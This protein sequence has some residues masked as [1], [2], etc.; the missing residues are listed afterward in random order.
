MWKR[1]LS[2]RLKR[3]EGIK[4]DRML[5]IGMT[6]A[7]FNMQSQLTTANNLANLQ[8]I[9]FKAQF[10][11]AKAVPVISN[12]LPTRTYGIV[13][14]QGINFENGAKTQTFNPLDIA[15]KDK[16]YIVVQDNNQVKLTRNGALQVDNEGFLKT[17]EGFKVMGENGPI[18]VSSRNKL[19][20]NVDGY[21]VSD[22][23]LM[24]RIMLV[25][26]S[27]ETLSKD[28]SGLLMSTE[29]L[30]QDDSIKVDVGF[31]EGS[32]VNAQQEMI[33]MIKLS[34]QFDLN[35]KVIDTANENAKS[36]QKILQL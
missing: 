28:N 21:V 33:N 15:L 17:K 27:K 7:K 14:T 24:D 26:P 23:T 34:R 25:N 29:A 20:I 18:Q 16:G 35:L 32:N 9:G 4:M 8:T 19:K 11:I 31:I 30:T 22:K 6:S 13:D 10:D 3:K 36:A 2:I 12:A 5:Y 1:I